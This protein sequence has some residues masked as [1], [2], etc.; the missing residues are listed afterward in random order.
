MNKRF[1]SLGI[2]AAV[3][4]LIFAAH[5]QT[6]LPLSAATVT[7]PAKLLT[8]VQKIFPQASSC[9]LCPNEK[10]W[11]LAFDAQEKLIGKFIFTDPFVQEQGYGGVVHLCIGASP[12]GRIVGLTL[13]D[14]NETPEV[15][16]FLK[17]KNFFSSWDGLDVLRSLSKKVDA[18]TSA[19]ET[20]QAVID[21]FQKRLALL[22]KGA[23]CLLAPKP[24]FVFPWKDLLAL[25]AL[26]FSLYIFFCKDVSSSWRFALLISNVVIFGFF[27]AKMFSLSLFDR[28]ITEGIP[29]LDVTFLIFVLTAVIALWKNKNF[30]CTHVCPFGSL[31]EIA[32]ALQ[33]KKVVVAYRH[34][35]VLRWFRAGYLFVIVGLVL[36]GVG[37]YLHLLEPFFTFTMTNVPAATIGIFIIFLIVSLFFPRF[38]CQFV[39]PTG[40]VMESF[41]KKEGRLTKAQSVFLVLC[42]LFVSVFVFLKA[43]PIQ[44]IEAPAQAVEKEVKYH[45]A[46]FFKALANGMVACEL[47][48]Q[49]CMIKEGEV[50][51]CRARKNINGKLY[52]LTYGQ[53]VAL[54]VDPIEK[55]PFSHVFPGT[56]S[57]SLATAGCNM[58]CKFCQNWEISQLDADKVEGEF[59]SPQVIVAK[60]KEAGAKTIAFTYTEPV[61]FYEYMMDIMQEAKK[62]G[63][64]CVM[65]SAGF[66]NEVPLR[67]LAK[68]LVAA[69]IDLKGFDEKFYAAFTGGHLETVLNTLKILKEEGVWVEITNLLIPGANDSDEMITELCMWVRDNLGK[70]TPVHFSRFYPMYKLVN[71][72]PTPIETL[73]RAYTIAKEIGLEFVYIGNVP[74]MQGENTFCPVC[75]NLLIK[76][77]GYTVLGNNIIDG[78]CPVCQHK[79]PG[80][81]N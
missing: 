79:I 71:L 15:V 33:K 34:A 77:V 54:H 12:E 18:V 80:V 7:D 16:V 21:A 23:S 47:C 17:R 20:M 29:W 74:D 65:H 27:T 36:G 28:W 46:S 59:V 76:R 66:V 42:L 41:L 3:V 61:I 37:V 35:Q 30:Y 44:E 39:C 13:T 4:L 52:A 43:K 24:G 55:K 49:K 2:L 11:S 6:S 51:F 78:H 67:Q 56:N 1:L 38:W 62:E 40:A 25:V 26:A 73:K 60:A 48:P 69:N 53:P 57:F 31:Q 58:R 70:E 10:E 75:R 81:W 63:V 9:A 64:A 22:S 5:R 8:E 50:G 32:G 45:L 72:S 14:H 68:Y 19:T